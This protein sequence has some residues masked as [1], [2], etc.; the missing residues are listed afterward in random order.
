MNRLRSA[1]AAAAPGTRRAAIRALWLLCWDNPATRAHALR[2]VLRAM[3]AKAVDVRGARSVGARPVTV[4]CNECRA[5]PRAQVLSVRHRNGVAL[6]HWR[7]A[8]CRRVL[9]AWVASASQSLARRA[10]SGAALRFWRQQLLRRAVRAWAAC[11]AACA[12][13]RVA[14]AKRGLLRWRVHVT[15]RRAARVRDM[16]A[17]RARDAALARR[18]LRAFA[19]N[20]RAALRE[21]LRHAFSA[22]RATVAAARAGG[23]VLLP[24][25]FL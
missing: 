6:R 2:V 22:W 12:L 7:R 9:T 15:H 8:V 25:T 20:A 19:R 5:G 16:L 11:A 10:A 4:V 21:R 3:S 23:L 14:L 13:G 1:V 18:G 17:V 24:E